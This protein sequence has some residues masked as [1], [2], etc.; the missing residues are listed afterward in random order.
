MIE[1]S[2]EMVTLILGLA[3]LAMT[4]FMQYLKSKKVEA[5]EQGDAILDSM[6]EQMD[7]MEQYSIF[8]PDTKPVI[9]R[10]KIL[11]TKFEMGWN[12]AKFSTDQMKDLQFEF[13]NLVKE[14]MDIIAKYK[15]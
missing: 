2:E 11:V 3:G 4:L 14:V 9:D 15:K 10:M 13:M 1:I 6:K 7:V 12:D 5:Y 8:V